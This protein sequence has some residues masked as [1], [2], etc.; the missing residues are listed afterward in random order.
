[1]NG[2]NKIFSFLE[3]IICFT[4]AIAGYLI[5]MTLLIHVIVDSGLLLV[6]WWLYIKG[7]CNCSDYIHYLPFFSTFTGVLGATV[8][9]VVIKFKE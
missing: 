9:M 8:T 4:F 2:L 7:Y 1:M 6:C 3:F 5:C